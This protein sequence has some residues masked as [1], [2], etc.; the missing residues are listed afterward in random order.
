MVQIE[1]HASAVMAVPLHMVKRVMAELAVA[2]S[3]VIAAASAAST[4]TPTAYRVDP[5]KSVATIHVGKAGAFSFMAGHTHEVRGPIES[6]AV[7]V[8]LETPARSRVHLVIAASALKVLAAGEPEGDPPKVEAAMQGDKVLDVQRFPRI[9]F[10][11]TGVTQTSRNGNVLELRVAGQLTIRD[12]A[13]PVTVPVRVQLADGGVTATGRFEIKQ[14]AFG[15]KPVS[16]GGVVA[17]K[18]ALDIEFSVVAA[19]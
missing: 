17:V 14:S 11:S 19:K 15:I 12:V 6:G 10:D 4:Q 16:V 8:D 2:M 13:Q 9:T 3:I 5:A 7:D 1:F 18:D